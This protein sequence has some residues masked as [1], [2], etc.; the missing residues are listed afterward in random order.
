VED[1]VDHCF[2]LA[3]KAIFCTDSERRAVA[4]NI[5]CM[6][7]GIVLVS[8]NGSGISAANFS[9]DSGGATLDEIKGYLRRCL[10][11]H[12]PAVRMEVYASLVALLPCLE[13]G[14]EEDEC[15]T[16]NDDPDATPIPIVRKGKAQAGGVICDVV[17]EILA[18][19]LERYI[20]P[21]ED[22]EDKKARRVRAMKHGSQLS[23]AAADSDE[24]EEDD[25][26]DGTTRDPP[27]CLELC[28]QE[29][30]H[31]SD[32]KEAPAEEKT[33]KGKKVGGKA[34][35]AQGPT[36]LDSARGKI[37]EPFC[38]L[39][40]SCAETITIQASSPSFGVSPES[41]SEEDLNE[42]FAA[43]K[44]RVAKSKLPDYLRFFEKNR[45]N[46]DGTTPTKIESSASILATCLMVASLAET[47]MGSATSGIVSRE[48]PGETT[49]CLFSLRSQAV[50]KAT[51]I[52]ATP[53]AKKNK[54]TT[55][56][57][58]GGTKK[59]KK[60]RQAT[61]DDENDNPNM[62]V[63]EELSGKD[64]KKAVL[65]KARRA[66]EDEIAT[67][68]PA[69]D[70]KVLGQFFRSFGVSSESATQHSQLTSVEG[71]TPKA[72]LTANIK[73][74]T[75]MLERALRLV[76]GTGTVVKAGRRLDRAALSW[77]RE[78][79]DDSTTHQNKY[80]ASA[81]LIGPFAF[82]EFASHCSKRNRT[83]LNHANLAA[84]EMPLSHLSLAVV[85]RC[86][87]RVIADHPTHDMPKEKRAFVWFRQVINKGKSSIPSIKKPFEFYTKGG[88]AP[89]EDRPLS[90]DTLGLRNMLLSLAAP[91]LEV[92]DERGEKNRQGG[93]LAELLANSM[94][95]EAAE[96]VRLIGCAGSVIP[97]PDVRMSLGTSILRCWEYA[98]IDAP[99]NG[100]L[101]LNHP[102]YFTHD[103]DDPPAKSPTIAVEAALILSSQLDADTPIAKIVTK[104]DATMRD[105]RFT[106]LLP[107]MSSEDWPESHREGIEK[108]LAD[109]LSAVGIA[110]KLSLALL[111]RVG[112]DSNFDD[113]VEMPSKKAC[114][115]PIVD[116]IA[117][118]Q[119]PKGL[120]V[121]RE[122]GT[123]AASIQEA[124]DGALTDAD[125]CIARILPHL[126]KGKALD[127]TKEYVAGRILAASS[128]ISAMS[129]CAIMVDDTA[130][131]VASLLKSCKRIYSTY[132]KLV[133]IQTKYDP[134]G[135]DT[136]MNRLLLNELAIKMT[137][138]T[139]CLL[140][141]MQEHADAGE[142][143]FM[144]DKKLASQGKVAAQVVYEKE[145]FDSFLTKAAVK[146]KKVGMKE[147][148]EEIEKF[149]VQ[150]I[151]RDFKIKASAIKAAQ[152]REGKK[153][154]KAGKKRKS[155][156]AE[157]KKKKQKK[158]KKEEA[159][160]SDGA[161]YDAGSVMDASV[162]DHTDS[163]VAASI[164]DEQ[165]TD[166]EE[167]S[168]ESDEELE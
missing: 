49:E 1:N 68:C 35:K 47:L 46:R 48:D 166:S 57:K 97:D 54:Q 53:T 94:E 77:K 75:F 106:S 101:G 17:A 73:F 126:S 45:E 78:G 61:G 40:A 80:I 44:K 127:Q 114:R 138:R 63:D 120:H 79:D 55:S 148:A 31:R 122:V 157:G 18:S 115:M 84:N 60:K 108:H 167:E 33:G 146:L 162:V 128:M 83:S 165:L 125:F 123:M 50:E 88:L 81:M 4:V 13:D 139:M 43:L 164:D 15:L 104:S 133:Q 91:V 116:T 22:K 143:K 32:Q 67:M 95:S 34:K 105:S 30:R 29:G 109:D 142:D 160:D 37:C 152:E 135:L 11:Q 149:V 111:L 14:R 26:D 151:N 163:S 64:I 86:L 28:L 8:A 51:L 21:E 103:Q 69:F 96:L 58:E 153:K 70:F 87:Q 25:E 42:I 85:V 141:S 38:F 107:T 5:L 134:S 24:D 71:Q 12:Q 99:W 66:I 10:T 161:D 6:L 145:R 129:G 20:T 110:K 62:S 36:L 89:S 90:E 93:L 27:I 82:A 59:K 65:D 23:Q 2:L 7:I 119:A 16:P 121:A 168:E 72:R 19:Q 92:Q 159:S 144:T 150:S 3:K 137:P 56:K 158:A 98:K 100:I 132:T 52:L 113:Q 112:R 76:D 74:R 102:E 155:D 117:A 124:I 41:Q 140:L 118:I 131:F 136:A 130:T 147:K 156:G 154:R 9:I 39:L